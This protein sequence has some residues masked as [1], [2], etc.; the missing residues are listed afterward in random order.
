MITIHQFTIRPSRA[1]LSYSVPTYNMTAHPVTNQEEAVL[2]LDAISTHLQLM[3]AHQFQ[4]PT[5][6]CCL[7]QHIGLGLYVRLH[8]THPI[9]NWTNFLSMTLLL[10]GKPTV[11]A[12]AAFCPSSSMSIPDSLVSF[13]FCYSQPSTH[14]RYVFCFPVFRSCYSSSDSTD[15]CPLCVL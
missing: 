1:T 8:G 3:I 14:S 12:I 11:G 10:F 4:D 6:P 9:S 2:M 15:V 13:L 5:A 7:C